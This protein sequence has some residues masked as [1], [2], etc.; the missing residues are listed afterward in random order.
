MKSKASF[1]ELK[2][3]LEQV[4][5]TKIRRSLFFVTNKLQDLFL[6]LVPDRDSRENSPTDRSLTQSSFS[7]APDSAIASQTPKLYIKD[8]CYTA[9]KDPG[10]ENLVVDI[11]FNKGSIPIKHTCIGEEISPPIRIDRI[12]AKY[13]A[14]IIED[15]V[16]PSENF[17]HWLIWNINARDFVP[18]NVPR[19]PVISNPFNA[20]QG[21][22]DF[23][24]IGFRGLNF[25]A[26]TNH[27]YYFNVYG[28]DR[29]LK[30][31]P[32]SDRKTLM[33]AMKGHM[34]QYGNDAITY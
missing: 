17:C 23:G 33:T 19:E 25:P 31:P 4:G 8:S 14:I 21:T 2:K 28:L 7:L 5:F 34:V 26:T 18:E 16:G 13:L 3:T 6:F 20:V 9:K 29:E 1:Q 11:G 27:R 15:L 24:S 10:M 22:N 12:R 30:I 32:G